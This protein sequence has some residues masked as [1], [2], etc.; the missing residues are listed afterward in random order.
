MDVIIYDTAIALYLAKRRS[1]IKMCGCAEFS[2]AN[3]H[4]EKIMHT[5]VLQRQYFDGNDLL[6]CIYL[7]SGWIGIKCSNFAGQIFAQPSTIDRRDYRN[8]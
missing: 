6:L 7:N 5:K 3:L 8:V 4:I 2:G 1:P